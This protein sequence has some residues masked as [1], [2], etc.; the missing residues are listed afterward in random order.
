MTNRIWIIAI[1][2]C[3]QFVFG[4]VKVT[5]IN[6]LDEYGLNYNAAGPII[7][8]TDSTHDRLAVLNTNSSMISVINCR[9][10]KVTNIPVGSRGI[11]HLK[12]T[13]III[14]NLTGIIYAA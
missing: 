9:D 14:D 3:S 1:F 11:Q 13:S 12:N 4:Q 2:T 8:R 5:E 7:T 10:H 6:F